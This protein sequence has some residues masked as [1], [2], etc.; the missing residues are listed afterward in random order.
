VLCRRA[1]DGSGSEEELFRQ[2]PGYPLRLGDISADGKFLS[3]DV[4]GVIEVMPL[5][6]NAREHIEFS[7]EEY[8]TGNGRFSGDGRFMAYTSAETGRTEVVVRSL[9]ASGAPSSQNGKVTTD[10]AIAV[11]SWRADS[12][13]LYYFKADMGD[14]LVMAVD[15]AT[16]PAVKAGEPRFLFSVPN[17]SWRL[18][19]ISRDGQRF[20]F[21]TN[22]P[23]T[24]SK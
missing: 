13:E 24:E 2:T 19:N 4:G 15:V 5:T 8:F 3:L 14:V 1:G 12:N 18:R 21:V 9:D 22:V 17:A 10:G 6:G 16:T 7:R 11:A 20:V 23:A